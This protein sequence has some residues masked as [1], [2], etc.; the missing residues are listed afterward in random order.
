MALLQLRPGLCL[1]GIDAGVAR[2]DLGGRLDLGWLH[3]LDHLLRCALRTSDVCISHFLCALLPAT[4]RLA[5]SGMV[6]VQLG[7]PYNSCWAARLP[8]G[9]SW[10]VGEVVGALLLLLSEKC[11]SKWDMLHERRLHYCQ[12]KCAWQFLTV[13]CFIV[14]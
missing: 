14:G 12:C 8:S 1:L 6:S 4:G 13:A 9:W 11:L 7:H 10:S 3:A 5:W 2:A